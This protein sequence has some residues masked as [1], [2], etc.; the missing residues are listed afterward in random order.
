[1]DTLIIIAC[2]IVSSSFFISS[3]ANN[4]TFREIFIG[5]WM[6]TCISWWCALLVYSVWQNVTACSAIALI[7]WALWPEFSKWYAK[8]LLNKTIKIWTKK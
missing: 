6:L 7:T 2:S 1:M 8:K 3:M 5:T 4:D